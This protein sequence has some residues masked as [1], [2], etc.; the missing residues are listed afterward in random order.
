MEKYPESGREDVEEVDDVGLWLWLLL[1]SGV[2]GGVSLSTTKVIE[3]MLGRR[4]FYPKGRMWGCTDA[5][6]TKVVGN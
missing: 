5:N 4:S 2:D 6:G 3:F 1:C